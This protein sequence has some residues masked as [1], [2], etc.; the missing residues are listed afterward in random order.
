MA[1]E[2]LTSQVKAL[3]LQLAVLKAQLARL[4]APP[5]PAVKSFGDLYGIFAGQGSVD[6]ADFDAVKYRFE[7]DGRLE[8]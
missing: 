6:E 7:W 2:S 4:S 5:A 8:G 1:P 3:E